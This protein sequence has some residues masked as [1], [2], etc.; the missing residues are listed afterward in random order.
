MGD[1]HHFRYFYASLCCFASHCLVGETS[2]DWSIRLDLSDW[3]GRETGERQWPRQSAHDHLQWPR[4]TAHDHRWPGGPSYRPERPH[5]PYY[6]RR[7][8]QT[9]IKLL[10]LD[11]GAS[12]I[13]RLQNNN[14]CYEN[15][16]LEAIRNGPTLGGLGGTFKFFFS[17][18]GS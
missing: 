18:G 17:G 14:N 15:R 10:H 13:L 6:P 1:R 9:A 11:E 2:P 4:Q 7:P 3:P 12:N 16:S 5:N 8:L